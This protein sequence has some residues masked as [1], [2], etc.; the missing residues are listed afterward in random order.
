MARDRV[1]ARSG[2][3]RQ[4]HRVPQRPH[5][6]LS[7]LKIIE[8]DQIHVV[9]H[10][11][12][13]AFHVLVS[14]ATTAPIRRQAGG[15]HSHRSVAS[16]TLTLPRAGGIGTYHL[17]WLAAPPNFDSQQTEPPSRCRSGPP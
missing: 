6:D 4:R 10:P 13:P 11:V 5:I 7:D 8:I 12:T 15:V 16:S 14:E 17:D 3:L 9:V 2:G 1:T